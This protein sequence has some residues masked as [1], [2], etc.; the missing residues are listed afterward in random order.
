MTSAAYTV[1]I[2]LTPEEKAVI[3]ALAAERGLT[4]P[5]DA[6]RVLLHEAADRYDRGWDERFAAHPDL[7]ERLADAAHADYLA[8]L[9]EPFDPDRDEDTP[10]TP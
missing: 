3:D 5:G 9:T 4:D 6:L 1:T 2:T 8:G 10:A 7:L